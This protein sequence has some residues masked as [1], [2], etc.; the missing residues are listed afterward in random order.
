MA[1]GLPLQVEQDPL[2]GIA[3]TGFHEQVRVGGWGVCVSV[4]VS[5]CK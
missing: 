1:R 3:L 2:H 5:V 4:C